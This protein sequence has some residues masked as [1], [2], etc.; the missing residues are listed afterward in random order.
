MRGQLQSETE[1]RTI[2]AFTEFDLV[3]VG[4]EAEIGPGVSLQTHLF[5]DQVMKMSKVTVRAG[6]TVGS[7]TVVLYDG[8]VG[9]GV[10]LDALSL[11]MKGEY[12]TPGTA[13]RGVPAQGRA[14]RPADHPSPKLPPHH[15]SH[16]R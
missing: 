11:V 12:L 10:W 14:L 15:T 6:A 4:D 5:E 13:W 3:E 8:V 7:R 16:S 9:E 2:P 1:T